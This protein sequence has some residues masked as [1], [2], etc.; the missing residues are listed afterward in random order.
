MS[1]KI[2]DLVSFNQNIHKIS[3]SKHPVVDERIILKWIFKVIAWGDMDWVYVT[4]DM[5]LGGNESEGFLV[6]V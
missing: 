4:R 2:T 5:W 1:I 3:Y 6:Y